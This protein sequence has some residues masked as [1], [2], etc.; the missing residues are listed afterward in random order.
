MKNGKGGSARERS[1]GA[2]DRGNRL[3]E[4]EV[5]LVSTEW[6]YNGVSLS[7]GFKLICM[8]R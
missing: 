5:A 2:H 1:V 8:G 7:N 3:L 6:T 4:G